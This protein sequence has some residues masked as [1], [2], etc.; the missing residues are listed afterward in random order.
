MW[1]LSPLFPAADATQ[2]GIE[3][4]TLKQLPS[5][6]H[7]VD[8]LGHKR[9][10]DRPPMLGRSAHAASPTGNRR[11]DL[12]KAKHGHQLPM[13]A[14]QRASLLLQRREETTLHHS[15]ILI[16]LIAKGKLQQEGKP[17]GW[18]RALTLLS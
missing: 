17:F 8:G 2:T 16:Q 6:A 1:Y 9:S 12:D 15:Q 5:M 14:G 3:S 10:R 4:K 13:L 11:F 18:I 7:V